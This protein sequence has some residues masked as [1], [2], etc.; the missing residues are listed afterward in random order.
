MQQKQEEERKRDRNKIKSNMYTPS[1]TQKHAT[2]VDF[3]ETVH[4]VRLSAAG[5][6]KGGLFEARSPNCTPPLRWNVNVW[7]EASGI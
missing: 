5:G 1:H 6:S 7:C 4:G 3:Q 2:L